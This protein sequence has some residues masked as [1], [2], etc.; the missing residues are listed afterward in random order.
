MTGKRRWGV[1]TGLGAVLA[2]VMA[3]AGAA[4]AAKL[5]PRSLYTTIDL[6]TCKTLRHHPDGN[7]WLCDGLP[8]YP[9]YVAEGDLR[10]FVSAGPDPEK[11]RA[12]T[13]TLRAFNHPFEG[14]SKRMTVEW[15]FYESVEGH[16]VPYAMIMRYVTSSDSGKGQVLI[17]SRIGDKETCH[18]AYIDAVANPNAIMIAR[19]IAD[20]RARTFDCQKEPAREGAIGRSP[21]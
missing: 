4:W 13:Q 7:A 8:G 20:Q 12:A 15:R 19:E 16:R 18:I 2:V 9:L 1:P 6:K 14:K 21:M 11:R 10:F 17:V 5:P 3:A